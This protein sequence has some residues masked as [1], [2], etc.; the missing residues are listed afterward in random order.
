MDENKLI[1]ISPKKVFR[2]GL[3]SVG[4]LLILLS[5]FALIG[6]FPLLVMLILSTS[7]NPS[8]I[9]VTTIFSVLMLISSVLI[10]LMLIG[11]YIYYKAEKR[12]G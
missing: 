2:I 1:S 12:V 10:L 11:L 9:A 6:I 8:S 4:A 5:G 3:R 7:L